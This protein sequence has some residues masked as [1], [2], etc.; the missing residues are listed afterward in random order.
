VASDVEPVSFVQ[1]Y[2]R[3][4]EQLA[5]ERHPLALTLGQSLV[6]AWLNP[7]MKP[8]AKMSISGSKP[9]WPK[10][11]RFGSKPQDRFRD[12]APAGRMTGKGGLANGCNEIRLG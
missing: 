10:I 5:P 4:L 8:A 7:H 1:G 3:F 6:L 2:L 11:F 9:E 12:R